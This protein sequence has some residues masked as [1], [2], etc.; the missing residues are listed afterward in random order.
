MSYLGVGVPLSTVTWGGMLN[1]GRKYMAQAWWMTVGPGAMLM[2]ATLALNLFG[3]G[4]NDAFD[5]TQKA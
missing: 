4:L 2:T 5:P 1:D 3:D